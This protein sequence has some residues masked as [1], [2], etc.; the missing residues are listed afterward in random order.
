[1]SHFKIFKLN[2]LFTIYLFTAS[3]HD[4]STARDV[5]L[6]IKNLSLIKYMFHLL[7][8]IGKEK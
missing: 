1:M 5:D 2:F 4:S 8:K 6:K 7:L 3:I